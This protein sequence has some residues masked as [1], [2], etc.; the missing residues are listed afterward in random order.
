MLAAVTASLATVLSWCGTVVTALTTETGAIHDLLP[1]FAIT[2]SVSAVM[3]GIK[4]I[5]SFVWGA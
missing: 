1:L 3:L 4:L 2:V 5:K